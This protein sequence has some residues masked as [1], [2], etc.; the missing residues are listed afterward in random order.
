MIARAAGIGIAV[1]VHLAILLFGGLLFF[2]P[3]EKEEKKKVEVV[4]LV[5]EDEQKDKARPEP[6]KV[7]EARDEVQEE[8][9]MEEANEMPDLRELERLDAAAAAPALEA[10]SLSALEEALNPGAAGGETFLAGGVDLT[11]GGRIGGTGKAGAGGDLESVFSIA[12]LDQ[13]PRPVFQAP[14]NY[15]FELR[16]RKVEGSVYVLF[17]VDEDGKVVNPKIEKTSN[18]GFDAPALEAVRQWKFEPGV[19][20]GQ[21]VRF[22]MRVPVR[23]AAGQGA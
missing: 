1:A 9:P 6:E 3:P 20:N 12:D 17:V 14:P 8:A 23:F 7:A 11:S 21:K 22:R 18:P 19:R 5:A 15:P 13:K 2:K 10:L 16:K 4:D